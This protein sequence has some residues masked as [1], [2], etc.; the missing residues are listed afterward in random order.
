MEEAL[1]DD[2]IVL[3]MRELDPLSLVLFGMTSK[4]NRERRLRPGSGRVWSAL[5][6]AAWRAI[7]LGYGFGPKPVKWVEKKINISALIECFGSPEIYTL[8]EVIWPKYKSGSDRLALAAHNFP[9]ARF[10]VVERKFYR[11]PFYEALAKPDYSVLEYIITTRNVPVGDAYPVWSDW[12]DPDLF[13]WLKAHDPLGGD[14]PIP[15]PSTNMSSMERLRFK[16]AYK[17][18][19]PVRY[20]RPVGDSRLLNGDEA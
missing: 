1:V 7:D 19:Q 13:D 18:Q 20:Y 9:L 2:V 11:L 3:I 14:Q 12:L 15:W 10:L 17:A 4:A 6:E 5:P 8:A 16:Q